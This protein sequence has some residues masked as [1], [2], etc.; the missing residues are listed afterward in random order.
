MSQKRFVFGLALGALAG[1]VLGYLLSGKKVTQMPD[2]LKKMKEK[3][4]EEGASENQ[5]SAAENPNNS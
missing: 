2:D 3:L 1:I 5:N 4:M